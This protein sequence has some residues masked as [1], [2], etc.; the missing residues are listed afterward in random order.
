MLTN[1]PRRRRPLFFANA[2]D[3]RTRVLSAVADE[4]ARVEWVIL[5]MEANVE[6]D[7]TAVDMLEDLRSELGSREIVLA[8]EQDLALYLERTGFL[9]RIGDEHVYPTLP[10]ALEG[11]R[12]RHHR[13]P[14]SPDVPD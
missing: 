1:I 4:E 8:L 13:P 12:S 6:I 3:F 9:A 2:E 5:N 11:F 14:P 10:T 7:L